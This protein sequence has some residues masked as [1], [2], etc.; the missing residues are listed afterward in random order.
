MPMEI[1]K[2]T[3]SDIF[4]SRSGNLSGSRTRPME[5]RRRR[6][7]ALAVAANLLSGRP[8]PLQRIVPGVAIAACIAACGGSTTTPPLG[9]DAR[10][11][12]STAFPLPG[13]GTC[14]FD[15]A[16][17]SVDA[18]GDCPVEGALTPGVHGTLTA[19]C[20][21]GSARA[22]FDG[23]HVVEGT[24]DGLG[25]VELRADVALASADACNWHGIEVL[26]GTTASGHLLYTDRTYSAA[27][28]TCVGSCAVSGV[29]AMTAVP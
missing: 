8:M 22:T 9:D 27:E 5:D 23:G 28:D 6:S 14:A 12:A 11:P 7:R 2:A 24:I 13:D 21:G 10:G 18:A 15:L 20:S 19:T 16:I 26:T 25:D 3:R 17:V 1:E 4:P 29:L